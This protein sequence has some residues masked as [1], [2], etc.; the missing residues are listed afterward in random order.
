M[1]RATRCEDRWNGVDVIKYDAHLV[2]CV[3]YHGKRESV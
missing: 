2:R 3:V 1:K